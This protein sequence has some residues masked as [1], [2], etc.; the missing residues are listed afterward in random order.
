M[1]QLLTLYSIGQC[2]KF[3]IK[4]T[5]NQIESFNKVEQGHSYDDGPNFVFNALMNPLM[6]GIDWS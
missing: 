3:M 1:S 6:I 2:S 4:L 5:H